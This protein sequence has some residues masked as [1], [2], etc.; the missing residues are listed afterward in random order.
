MPKL[1]SLLCACVIDCMRMIVIAISDVKLCCSLIPAAVHLVENSLHSI[2]YY[3]SKMFSDHVKAEGSLKCTHEYD[4][5]NSYF[6]VSQSKFRNLQKHVHKTVI[7][8]FFLS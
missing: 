1:Y 4:I 8:V 3:E 5:N 7:L 6:A 2:T